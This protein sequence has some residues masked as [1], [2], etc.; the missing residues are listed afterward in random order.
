MSGR[1]P[2]ERG[3]TPTPLELLYDLTY[4]I[5]FSAAA[6]QLSHYVGRGEVGPAIGAYV[7]AIFSVSWAWMNFT[8][9]SSAYG[10]DDALFRIATIVQMIGVVV[11][12]FGL[13]VSFSAAES[14]HSPNNVLMVVGYIVMRVPSSGCGCE[15]PG[16][17]R[18]IGGSR[19]RMR[20]SSRSR[21]PGGRSRRSRRYR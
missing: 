7:F 21:R 4:V 18:F 5:A 15:P 13:P 2:G 3:R 12:T 11:L 10:N 20:S 14:G 8:W 1:D 17:I 9:F 19:S 16:R 6:E